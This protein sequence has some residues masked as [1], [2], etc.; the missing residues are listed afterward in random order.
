MGEFRASQSPYDEF[1]VMNCPHCNRMNT[2]FKDMDTNRF[3][4][5]KSLMRRKRCDTCGVGFTVYEVN[6]KTD[7]VKNYYTTVT[8]KDIRAK[9]YFL[10]PFHSFGDPKGFYDPDRIGSVLSKQTS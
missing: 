6:L 4:I 3:V 9:R 7:E 10:S 1:V 5:N 2:F 8:N